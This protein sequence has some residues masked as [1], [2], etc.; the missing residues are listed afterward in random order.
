MVT[1]MITIP[2]AKER[3]VIPWSNTHL[4]DWMIERISKH[5][6]LFR[7]LLVL[8]REKARDIR[9]STTVKDMMTIVLER[10][11]FQGTDTSSCRIL[12]NPFF[13][14]CLDT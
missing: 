11:V 7:L 2:T 10:Y 8:F 13:R 1:V 5:F 9:T 12:S 14:A 4:P 6:L 3:Y